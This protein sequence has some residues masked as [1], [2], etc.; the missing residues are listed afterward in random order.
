MYIHFINPN[1]KVIDYFCNPR[2]CGEIVQA[3]AIGISNTIGK[4][5]V[6]K[7]SIKIIDKTISEIK[8]KALGCATSIA[9]ASAITEL[10]KGKKISTALTL[11]KYDIS[12]F[13]GKIPE[14]KIYCCKLAI[15]A[16][17]NAIQNYM[18]KNLK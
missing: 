12:E 5:I 18:N 1:S 2:N 15:N 6:I 9:S 4:G 10:V 3:D 7:V 13:L 16:L 17:H 8:F 11:T 14:E